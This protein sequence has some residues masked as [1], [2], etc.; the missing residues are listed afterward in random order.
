VEVK[1][2]VDLYEVHWWQWRDDVEAPA[3][4]ECR[5]EPFFSSDEAIDFWKKL[6]FNSLQQVRIKRVIFERREE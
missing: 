3:R 2:T 5:S 6:V 4:M 1:Q